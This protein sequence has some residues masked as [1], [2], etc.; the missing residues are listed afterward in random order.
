VTPQTVA[1]AQEY[2]DRYYGEE[3]IAGLGT[4]D[5][6]AALTTVPPRRT[7]L[8]LGAGSESLLWSIPLQAER[9][10]AVDLDP[11][12]LRILR[13]CA[14]TQQPRGAYRTVLDLCGRAEAD[15]A[16]RCRSLAA[17]LAADC[18]SSEPLPFMPASIDLVTQFGLLGL[19]TSPSQFLACW[20]RAHA[21]LASGGW[22]A[23][24]NWNATGPGQDRAQLTRQLYEGSFAA[25]GI[26]PLLIARVPIT[27]DA[28]FD[29]VWIY[30]GR[31]T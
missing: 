13:A 14:A 17:T 8:D 2:W 7:W 31:K 6:L 15:F 18:L 3:F 10:I 5:I 1:A 16:I 11:A 25:A 22:C 28:D 19:T 21:P 23:G 26:M 30:L 24:A 27:G 4:E 29:S 9:L 12:R 20:T